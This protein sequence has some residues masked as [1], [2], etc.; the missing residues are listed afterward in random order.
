MSKKFDPSEAASSDAGI[1][2]LPYTENESKVVL[3][4]VPWEVTTSYGRGA[5]DGPELIRRASEQVDLFDLETGLAFEAGY[6]M[7]PISKKI[8]NKN[9]KFK[10]MAQKIVCLQAKGIKKSEITSLQK[11]VNQACEEVVAWVQEQSVEILN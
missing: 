4:P 5:A 11:Q 1:F 10:K 8:A 2:G 6:S 9:K 7:R 3:L